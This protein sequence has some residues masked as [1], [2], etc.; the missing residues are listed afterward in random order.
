[1]SVLDDI[2]A[3]LEDQDIVPLTVP[4]D[5]I[6]LE[7]KKLNL[8]GEEAALARFEGYFVVSDGGKTWVCTETVDPE[9]GTLTIEQISPT[10]FKDLYAHETV[11]TARGR[12]QA[13]PLWLRAEGRPTYPGGFAL[14]PEQTAP[15]GV[16]NLWRGFGYKPDKDATVWNA[17]PFLW[18]IKY[19]ICG[20]DKLA[21]KYLLGWLAHAVQYPAKQAEVAV[22]LIGGRGTGK[23]TLGRY[24][25]DI[26]GAHGTH[27]QSPEHLTG[28]FTGHLRSTIGLFVDEAFFAG[29]RA[30]NNK[31]KS[32][33]TEDRI[34]LES[35]NMNAY[36]AKNRLKIMMATNE[37]FAISAGIDER[38][39]FVVKVSDRAKQ[40]HAYFQRLNQWWETGGSSALLTLLQ[41]IDLSEFNIRK[42]P[43]TAALD[44]QKL[45][46]LTGLDAWLFEKLQSEE[47]WKQKWSAEEISRNFGW[48]C[49]Q[50]G[51]RYKYENT[52]PR[53]VGKGLRQ[54]LEVN[55]KREQNTQNRRW[56]LMLPE[57]Q[58]ARRQFATKLDM[59][60]D[61][62]V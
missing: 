52:S 5:I 45:E 26:F 62:N 13:A 28:R 14:L 27:I 38:R 22:V 32:L 15:P 58:E 9:L 59:R 25:R 31:L 36:P 24:F 34:M 10:A 29:D 30:S 55:R 57:L 49:D 44:Q 54:W 56:V 16:Y 17:R 12:Q 3:K 53:A 47:N 50:K 1:M 48:Y 19:V 6:D 8:S 20:G 46:A 11:M 23:G 42:V 7:Q 39:F 60:I 35:K 61:W 33:I 21:F 43:N 4:A 40:D 51:G 18:H 41:R 37:Q 2:K